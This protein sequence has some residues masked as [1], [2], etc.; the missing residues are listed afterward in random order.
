[1]S[2]DT[3]PPAVSPERILMHTLP[4][5]VGGY[6]LATAADCSLFTHLENGAGTAAALA[7]RAGVSE[8]GVQALLDGLVGM[9]LVESQNGLYRNGPEASAFLVEG[10]PAYLGGFARMILS[11]PEVYP[12]MPEA[13]RSGLPQATDDLDMADHPM[14]RELVLAIVP[15]A[16]PLAHQVAEQTVRDRGPISILDIGG[17][18]GVYS[19]VLLAANPQ[20]TSTQLDWQTVNGIAREFVGG[21]G[22]GDR[23]STVDGDFHTSDLGQSA[24]DVIVYSNIAHSESPEDNVA[25]FRRIRRALRPG[26]VLVISDFVLDADGRGHPFSGLFSTVML[27][28][29]QAGASWRQPDYER[30]LAEAGFTQVRFQPTPSPST[31]IFAS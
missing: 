2:A 31:L 23:F 25:V 1:M 10:R 11:R 9:G 20:A 28:N 8:R 15:L 22:A 27:M 17:G 24:H 30:W 5:V 3:P 16:L 26:G 4:A 18:S 19:A 21:H 12:R 7:D 6:V 29:T 13:V 14:W